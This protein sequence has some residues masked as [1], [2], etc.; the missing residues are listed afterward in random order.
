M[1]YH[2]EAYHR[3]VRETPIAYDLDMMK[4]FHPQALPPTQFYDGSTHLTYLKPSRSWEN[5]FCEDSD[6][7]ECTV[8][9][10]SWYNRTNHQYKTE[11]HPDSVKGRSLH[12]A[13]DIPKGAFINSDDVQMHLHIDSHQWEALN[14]FIEDFPEA[15]L[16]KD[17]RN[18]FITYGFENEPVGL[19]GWSVSV[20][21]NNTFTNHGCNAKDRNV[22]SYPFSEDPAVKELAASTSSF[23]IVANR[24]PQLMMA[25]G[26]YKDIKKGEEIAMD[27]SAFRTFPD[28]KFTEFLNG[29]CNTGVGLVDAADGSAIDSCIDN[30]TCF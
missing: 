3:F 11:V 4:R 30:S 9:R 27:Y 8:L 20:A 28:P 16:Y 10:K 5:W 13:E 12:A 18:F 2:S 23:S 21:S 29:I 19:S 7:Y 26:T 6:S 14:V 22:Q 17:L 1:Q 15:K 24:R 25:T